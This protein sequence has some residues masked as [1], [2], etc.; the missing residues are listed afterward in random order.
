M[1]LYSP[2]F[3]NGFIKSET[4]VLPG[5]F[6][7]MWLGLYSSLEVKSF[8]HA[9]VT[10]PQGIAQHRWGDQQFYL[11]T[12]ALFSEKKFLMLSRNNQFCHQH[13][14]ESIYRNEFKKHKIVY[15]PIEDEK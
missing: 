14:M 6:T 7:V 4:Y 1:F 9:F 13:Q 15:Y 2:N 11:M 12:L 10:Y 5:A 8:A 3:Y